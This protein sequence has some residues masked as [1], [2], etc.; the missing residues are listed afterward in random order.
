MEI[1][2]TALAGTL[3]SSDVQIMV[4]S[5]NRG[6]IIEIESPVVKQFGKQIEKVIM[7][8][9][10]RMGVTSGHIKVI[11]KGALDCT[12][13]ARLITALNRSFETVHEN[14]AWEDL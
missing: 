4:S 11:D 1:K 7:E 14:L 3:E 9:L 6:I 12:I 10:Q 2:K 8:V 13:R 5:S